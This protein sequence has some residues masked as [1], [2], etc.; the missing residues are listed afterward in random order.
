MPEESADSPWIDAAR[1][2]SVPVGRVL[3]CSL[4]GHEIALCRLDDGSLHAVGNLCTH[5]HARL[6][7]GWL[8]DGIL[9]CP[10]HGGQ[11]DVRTGVGVCGPVERPLPVYEV[12]LHEGRVRICLPHDGGTSPDVA[13]N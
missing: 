11:F 12:Q 7:D 5:E 1:L 6:S 3:G 4:R 10:F 2:D 8:M 9:A 13:G